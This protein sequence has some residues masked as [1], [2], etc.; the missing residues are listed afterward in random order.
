LIGEGN[1]TVETPTHLILKEWVLRNLIVPHNT[2]IHTLLRRHELPPTARPPAIH[3]VQ[4]LLHKHL[5]IPNKPF[6]YPVI[7]AKLQLVPKIWQLAF[8]QS[9]RRRVRPRR[10]TVGSGDAEHGSDEIRVPLCDAVDGGSTPVVASEDELR[11]VNLAG[12]GGDGVGV[13]AEA[14]VL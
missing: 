6:H 1:N 7:A 2:Q 5:V 11:G 13:G 12:D 4:K 9:L 3:P 14:V 8:G 10:G